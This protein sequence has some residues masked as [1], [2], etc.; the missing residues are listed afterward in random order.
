MCGIEQFAFCFLGSD[1]TEQEN[2][3]GWDSNKHLLHSSCLDVFFNL[4]FYHWILMSTHSSCLHANKQGNPAIIVLTLPV[5]KYDGLHHVQILCTVTIKSRHMM[6]RKRSI[7][8]FL[9]SSRT[10]TS[11]LPINC[12]KTFFCIT[13]MLTIEHRNHVII[14]Y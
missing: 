13:Q 5:N 10:K 1:V 6:I 11:L 9:S 3:T 2:R 12:N 14:K 8:K 4:V 7:L